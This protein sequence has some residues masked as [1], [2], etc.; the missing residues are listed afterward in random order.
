[1]EFF[2]LNT[3]IGLIH[4]C[5]WLKRTIP[6]VCDVNEL[7]WATGTDPDARP[8]AAEATAGSSQ[9]EA[10]FTGWEGWSRR[11]TDS[12]PQRSSR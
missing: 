4:V 9:A 5:D 6:D 1:M 7:V 11:A 8:P 12:M 3:E 10:I 2:Y